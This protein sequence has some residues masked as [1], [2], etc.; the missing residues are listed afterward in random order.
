MISNTS[1]IN[2]QPMRVFYCNGMTT[3][4][5]AALDFCRDIEKKT[6][7][8][9]ELVHN[10]TTP[11]TQVVSGSVKSAI[12]ALTMTIGIVMLRKQKPI[13]KII[14][15]A[16]T[17][18]GT[19]LVIWGLSEYSEI[20]KKKNEKA[21]QLAYRLIHHLEN[22]PTKWATLL[23]HS[24]GADIGRRALE[25]MDSNLRQRIN[26]ITIGGMILIP[27]NLVNRV[28]NIQDDSDDISKTANMF[29]DNEPGVRQLVNT[30]QSQCKTMLCHSA[31][32]YLNSQLIKWLTDFSCP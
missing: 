5:E 27:K 13:E 2:C 30:S 29:F 7:T 32:D 21:R 10:D 1:Q 19:G 23:L 28:V 8:S 12:G 16:L 22:N 24:Q 31:Q 4:E 17:I 11:S 6:G 20:Q 26:V 18:L 14:A 15:I 25:H 3:T 9:V